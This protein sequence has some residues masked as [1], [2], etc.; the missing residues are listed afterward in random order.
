MLLLPAV[1]GRDQTMRGSGVANGQDL[2][3][4]PR[5]RVPFYGQQAREGMELGGSVSTFPTGFRNPSSVH[6]SRGKDTCLVVRGTPLPSLEDMC[7][8]EGGAAIS[9]ITNFP[10][11]PSNPSPVTLLASLLCATLTRFESTA[12]TSA[13]TQPHHNHRSRKL[14]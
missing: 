7:Y 6:V 1:E 2:P 4:E 12:S 11:R 3:L 5:T 9:S 14:Q 8:Q 10:S 13:Q